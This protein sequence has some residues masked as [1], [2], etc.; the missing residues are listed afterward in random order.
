MVAP[1]GSHES[2]V[3]GVF[4][5]STVLIRHLAFWTIP[6]ST[7]AIRIDKMFDSSLDRGCVVAEMDCSPQE[8]MVFSVHDNVDCSSPNSQELR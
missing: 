6:S 5:A 8:A 7:I 2:V 3:D 4:D 1:R